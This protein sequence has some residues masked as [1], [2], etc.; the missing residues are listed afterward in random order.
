MMVVILTGVTSLVIGI[1]IGMLIGQKVY[2]GP[3]E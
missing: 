3:K 2:V 1:N